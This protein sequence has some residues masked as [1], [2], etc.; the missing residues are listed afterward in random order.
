MAGPSSAA[1]YVLVFI[2]IIVFAVSGYLLYTSLSMSGTI[3]GTLVPIG[4]VEASQLKVTVPYT[5]AW[6]LNTTVPLHNVGFNP[7]VGS[8][9]NLLTAASLY[10]TSDTT[11]STFAS[12]STLVFP[13]AGIWSLSYTATLTYG[14]TADAT[15]GTVFEV[16]IQSIS[17]TYGTSS[18]ANAEIPVFSGCISY[19][20]YFAAGDTIEFGISAPTGQTTNYANNGGTTRVNATLLYEV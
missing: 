15:A 18:I 4:P 5:Y 11:A 7:L 8:S 6:G 17:G 3:T 14:Y 20:G 9:F 16:I 1:F 10:P 2:V 13:M 12:D 19:C